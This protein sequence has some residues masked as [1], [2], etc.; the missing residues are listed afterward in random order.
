MQ[1]DSSFSLI[2]AAISAMRRQRKNMPNIITGI[3]NP[4]TN[5]PDIPHAESDMGAVTGI[6]SHGGLFDLDNV[7][8]RM[9]NLLVAARAYEANVGVLGRYKQMTETKLELLG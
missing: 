2:D 9:T 3:D 5:I 4:R 8:V 1:I 6:R 7:P